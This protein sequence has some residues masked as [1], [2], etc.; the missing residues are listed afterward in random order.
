ML[1]CAHPFH[2]ARENGE[3][4]ARPIGVGDH[5]DRITSG[6]ITDIGAPLYNHAADWC[7]D[8]IDLHALGAF[9]PRKH[10]SR[11]DGIPHI[12]PGTDHAARKFRTHV[13]CGGRLQLNIADDFDRFGQAGRANALGGY[14]RRLGGLRG[15]RHPALV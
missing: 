1:P 10:L 4:R 6:N 2:I 7:G 9:D 3:H 13:G 12:W 11:P 14:P 5:V 8:R 15:E